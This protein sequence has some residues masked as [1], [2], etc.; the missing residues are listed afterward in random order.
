MTRRILEFVTLS[1]LPRTIGDVMERELPAYTRV[2]GVLVVEDKVTLLVEKPV[3]CD[4][5]ET[6]RFMVV[7]VGYQFSLPAN[8]T[9]LG[10][11]RHGGHHVAVYDV[12]RD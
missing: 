8:H 4:R 3:E 11:V 10:C 12:S 5:N 1:P 2:K 9:Y 7:L 6:R